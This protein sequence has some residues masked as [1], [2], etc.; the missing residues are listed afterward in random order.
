MKKKCTLHFSSRKLVLV[1]CSLRTILGRESNKLSRFQRY[2]SYSE[3]NKHSFF[4]FLQL[5]GLK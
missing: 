4:V 3:I 5:F 2:C 1:L